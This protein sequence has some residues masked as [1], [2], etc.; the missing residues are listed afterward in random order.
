MHDYTNPILKGFNPDPSILRVGE[1][2]YI[3]TSTFEWFPGV[4]IHHS[5]DLVNWKLVARP[6][7]RVSQLDLKGIP[8]SCGVWAPC[9]SYKNGVFYLVYS[10]VKSFEGQW[11][12]TPNFVVTSKDILGPWSEPVYLSSAGFDGSFFHDEDGTTWYLSM[13][14]DHTSENLFGGII[15]Q[16]YDE[17][18]KQLVGEQF[19]LT[20][21]T[22]LG[23]TEGPHIYKKDGFY[24]L[25]LAE[26]G[27][28]YGH[29]VTVFR[30][31]DRTS[32][33]EPHP[34]NPILSARNSESNALQKAGHAS[35][36]QT[37]TGKWYI[38]FLVGRPLSKRGRCTLGRETAIEEMEWR[39]G[40]PYLKSGAI[41]PRLTIPGLELLPE[42]RN[43]DHSQKVPFDSG[44]LDINFQS[45]RIPISDEWCSLS[46][47]D[48]YLSLRGGESLASTH[49]QS[50][51]ARR[52]QHFDVEASTEI[53]FSP[54]NFQQM[55]GL[56]FYYN[57]GHYYYLNIRGLKGEKGRA[58][59]LVVCDN[60]VMEE[61]VSNVRL[62]DTGSI[63]LKARMKYDTLSFSYSLD[64]GETFQYAGVGL[65]ATILSDDY[66]RE[67]SDR[68]RPAF[69]G[70]FAGMCCQDLSTSSRHA[71]FKWFDYKEIEIGKEYEQENYLR[72]F[73]SDI[74]DSL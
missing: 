70:S 13:L 74:G 71:D 67:G 44:K 2:Y 20:E 61:L 72:S 52:I 59:S 31:K 26:G 24:Y 6:L 21:G 17:E 58:L 56:V 48:G 9:L 50:M 8:D 41:E 66:V 36:V 29:A 11:K 18:G 69:T 22:E 55:A 65:D 64:G 28:E 57:T 14:L 10:N 30:S 15:M 16:Q 73:G 7:E 43:G 35:I 45:L 23:C 25:I 42:Q 54:E 38:A 27:T 47:R 37:Q 62:P 3:A 1:D 4:Q 51:I 39:D 46:H 68:Y 63:I 12:D 32:G 49:N 19:Y 53:E 40:W 34:S 5:K 33:Y 60:F